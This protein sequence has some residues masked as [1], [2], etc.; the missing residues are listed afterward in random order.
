[1]KNKIINSIINLGVSTR[2]FSHVRFRIRELKNKNPSKETTMQI[3]LFDDKTGN[4]FYKHLS[5]TELKEISNILKIYQY[6][7]E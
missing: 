4:V 7:K 6:R 3:R 5:Q 1:M 2:N